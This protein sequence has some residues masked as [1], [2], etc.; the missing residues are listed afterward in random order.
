[1]FHDTCVSKKIEF[2]I[3]EFLEN[4]LAKDTI[5]STGK[6]PRLKLAMQW[7]IKEVQRFLRFCAALEK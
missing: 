7:E 2:F 3:C 4:E 5:S 1:M 6:Y